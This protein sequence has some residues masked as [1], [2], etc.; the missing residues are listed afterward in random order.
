MHKRSCHNASWV[1]ISSLYLK[2]WSQLPMC[3]HAGC[4]QPNFHPNRLWSWVTY[5]A[6][7]SVL[8]AITQHSDNFW[9][10]KLAVEGNTA[11]PTGSKRIAKSCEPRATGMRKHFELLSTVQWTW[12]ISKKISPHAQWL[13]KKYPMPADRSMH[14]EMVFHQEIAKHAR[15]LVTSNKGR[16]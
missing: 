5:A 14:G 13:V 16:P 12:H 9:P 8:P 10:S 1:K 4:L 15:G 3:A 11:L 6:I 7:C 2:P